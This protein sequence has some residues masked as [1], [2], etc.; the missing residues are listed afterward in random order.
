[1]S[2]QSHNINSINIRT[3]FLGQGICNRKMLTWL[4][5]PKHVNSSSPLKRCLGRLQALGNLSR[6]SQAQNNWHRHLRIQ[7]NQR[8]RVGFRVA[9]RPRMPPESDLEKMRI[10]RTLE[11]DTASLPGS[12]SSKKYRKHCR[13]TRRRLLQPLG[14]NRNTA[15]P[16]KSAAI[17]CSGPASIF[18]KLKT[19]GKCHEAVEPFQKKYEG[20]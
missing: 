6:K 10:G 17:T 5:I 19:P 15:S 3:L 8:R 9:P 20:S 14:G 1:M 2:R 4:G 13:K 18:G 12:P 16:D 7:R 11:L